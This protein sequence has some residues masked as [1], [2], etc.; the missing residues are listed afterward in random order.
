MA[1]KPKRTRRASEPPPKQMR[2]PG[3]EIQVPESV[4][5]LRDKYVDAKRQTAEWRGKSNGFR[6]ELIGAMKEHG[7]TV[8]E[9]DDGEK[10]LRQIDKPALEITSK[11][12]ASEGDGED[13]GDE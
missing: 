1:N 2:I 8:L 5:T 13:E 12:P 3:T 6:D 7:I 4:A 10:L 9:I 11:K